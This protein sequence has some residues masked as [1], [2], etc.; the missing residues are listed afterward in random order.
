VASDLEVLT[1]LTLDASS[2]KNGVKG[3]E[4][5]LQ[6]TGR[7]MQ[8]AGRSLTM[9]VTAPLAAAGGAAV[10]TA[11]D[12][13]SGMK[14]VQALSG[15]TGDEF[16]A[17]RTKAQEI[18]RTTAF[19]AKEA[20]GGLAFLS[21][22][23]FEA[24]ESVS[25]L[26]GVTDLAAAGQMDLARAG[27]VASNVLKGYGMQ[28]EDIGRVNDVLAETATSSNSSIA[29]LGQ[30]FSM[31]GS[32]A[33]SA[34]LKFEETA[35]LLGQMGDAGIQAGRAGRTLRA[36]IGRLLDPS[37][38]TQETL[39]RLGVSATDSEGNLRSMTSIVGDLAEAGASTADIMQIF[40]KRAGPGMQV[41]L[42]EGVGGLE[43]FQS[44]LESSA[45]A[46]GEMA[47][48][49]L[50]GLEGRLKV[51]TSSM[52]GLA[53]AIADTGLLDMVTGLVE[54]VTGFVN[55]IAS[56]NPRL[57]KWG[58]IVA[59]AAAAAGPLLMILGAFLTVLPQVVGTFSVLAGPLGIVTGLLAA[60][61]VAAVKNFE[62]FE[63]VLDPVTKDADTL[64]GIL[65]GLPE[66]LANLVSAVPWQRLGEQALQLFAGT[67]QR[68]LDAVVN[69]PWRELGAKASAMVRVVVNALVGFIKSVDWAR[70]GRKAQAMVSTLVDKLVAFIEGVDWVGVA[71]RIAVFVATLVDKLVAFIKAVD[72]AAVAGDILVF[73]QTLVDKLVAFLKDVDWVKVGETIGEKLTSLA[74]AIVDALT[75][76]LNN[77]T[78]ED[79]AGWAET[80]ASAVWQTMKATAELGAGVAKGAI[81]GLAEGGIVRSPTL[82]VIGEAGPE[83]VVPLDRYRDLQR[84][85][86]SPGPQSRP[87]SNG[88]S[89]PR[90]DRVIQL[91]E[92][93]LDAFGGEL[94][95]VV[96]DGKELGRF[97]SEEQAR[98]NRRT[99]VS[100]SG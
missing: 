41:L 40:G 79:V 65:A 86:R 80:L 15:A 17:M 62:K 45:G 82:S 95:T 52:E 90:D 42:D 55:R 30:A 98:R 56:A 84:A 93:L 7:R 10:K 35:A 34:G 59:G 76:M 9:G 12:F 33:N 68:L 21:K 39:A 67:T 47:D 3:A 13:E 20:A 85:A 26:Q 61:G 2:F 32:V 6:D 77:L 75:D 74:A 49:Q 91:L 57:L 38:E 28:A 23:G 63:G 43:D 64:G 31:A 44:Q 50:E 29:G 46:A 58:V 88:S 60:V 24:Q 1:R 54:K 19:S 27:D 96:L 72:W 87:L 4:K 51:L 36:A 71:E 81:P 11:A 22:A 83:A 48:K 16:E 78:M 18:G 25:A 94:G 8:S 37:K 99:G 97:V 69:V 66:V 73:V 89:T 5:R 92:E 14:R 53:I 100:P 70:L